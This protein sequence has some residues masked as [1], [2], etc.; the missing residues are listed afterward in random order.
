MLKHAD[1]WKRLTAFMSLHFSCVFLILNM[2]KT[3]TIDENWADKEIQQNLKQSGKLADEKILRKEEGNI[4]EIV[5]F[6]RNRLV[7]LHYTDDA[8]ISAP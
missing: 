4:E 5:F 8:H 6:N 3:K 1:W 7:C 2:E